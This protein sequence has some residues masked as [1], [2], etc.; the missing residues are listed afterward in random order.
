MIRTV[1]TW[2]EDS[3]LTL[4]LKPA[5]RKACRQGQANLQTA[6]ATIFGATGKG[7]SPASAWPNRI[8]QSEKVQD[9]ALSWT[10]LSY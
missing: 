8:V 4:Q 5:L 6:E 10:E 1:I 7:S 2:N 3:R 9:M